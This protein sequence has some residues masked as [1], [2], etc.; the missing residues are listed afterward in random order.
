[1]VLD[2]LASEHRR[3]S[4]ARGVSLEALRRT[5]GPVA[6]L[7]DAVLADLAAEGAVR[8]EGS[9]AARADHVPTLEP[10]GQALAEAATDRLLR[11]RLAPPG[12]KELAAEL[13]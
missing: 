11:D 2:V 8:I 9:V 6:P 10:E 3:D 5:A 7:V 1:G 12:L 13:G 4:G